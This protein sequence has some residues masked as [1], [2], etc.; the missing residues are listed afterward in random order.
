MCCCSG[1]ISSFLLIV[2]ILAILS[3]VLRK[4]LFQPS[5]Y[6]LDNLII[7]L[8][9]FAPHMSRTGDDPNVLG[10]TVLH[11]KIN[12]GHRMLI[13]FFA[14]DAKQWRARSINQSLRHEG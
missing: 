2:A 6:D 9:L 14:V 10:A 12:V 3:P 8:T 4:F 5:G 11:K 7:G 1:A 13:V